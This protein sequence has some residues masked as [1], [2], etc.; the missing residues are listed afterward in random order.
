MKL[1]QKLDLVQGPQLPANLP[2][3]SLIAIACGVLIAPVKAKETL[4]GRNALKS[5]SLRRGG[6][7]SH[8]GQT[9]AFPSRVKV[10][11]Q[12]SSFIGENGC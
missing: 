3:Q 1:G 12:G 5:Y 8:F 9:T 7:E 2:D 11:P 10:S 6:H 4:Q